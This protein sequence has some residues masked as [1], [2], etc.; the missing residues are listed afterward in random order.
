MGPIRPQKFAHIVYRTRRFEEMLGWYKTV[1]GAKVQLEDGTVIVA[2]E[3]YITESMM[4]PKAKVHRGFL[5]V[6]PSF[7]D[8]KGSVIATSRTTSS[9]GTTL[10]SPR[11]TR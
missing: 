3:A 9:S 4:D 6:M 8:N 7:Q 10:P 11:S 5:P 1:F 2:D